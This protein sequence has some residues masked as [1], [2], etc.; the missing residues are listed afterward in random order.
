MT[1]LIQTQK[2]IV[3]HC[4]NCGHFKSRHVKGVGC[5]VCDYMIQKGWS[6]GPRCTETFKSRLS[7]SEIEQARKVS[8]DEYAG[9]TVCATCLSIWWS[10]D[11]LLCPNG[12]TLFVP[13]IGGG[14]A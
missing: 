11:G 12:E 14:A 1:T 13:M 2:S 8:K 7:E 6:K 3:V 10:H 5:V 4:P 9:Q